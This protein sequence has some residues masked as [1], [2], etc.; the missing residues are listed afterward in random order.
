M[1]D[2]A[3]AI[4]SRDGLILL[5]ARERSS[6]VS[7]WS[8]P[9]GKIKFS[10]T[11]RQ[12]C[13]RELREETSIDP[14]RLA[15]LFLF[16]GFAKRHHVFFADLAPDASVEPCNEISLCEWFSPAEIGD[17]PASTPTRA[18]VA[19]FMKWHSRQLAP[20]EPAS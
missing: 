20:G 1:R 4:C 7:R 12:A 9:G 10:E 16:G 3:T 19:L 15:Y 2:R 13:R 17:L 5:V 8:L 6:R 18:I 14:Q 11:P